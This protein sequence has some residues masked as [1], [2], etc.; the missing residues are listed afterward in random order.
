M[1]LT[2]VRGITLAEVNAGGESAG[3]TG[4]LFDL[5]AWVLVAAVPFGLYYALQNFLGDQTLSNGQSLFLALVSGAVIMWVFRLVP[6]FVPGL[7]LILVAV[8]MNLVPQ[9]IAF[10]GFYSEVFFLIFGIFVL[11]AL[12][13]ETSWLSRLEHLLRRKDA[14]LGARVMAILGSG[15]VL[16]LI[17]PS[18]LGRAAMLQ[19]LVKKFF[20][21]AKPR[22]NSILALVH[23]HA[24]TLISTIILTGNPL[25]FVLL[26]MLSEQARGRYQW[27]GWLK[28][29]GVAGLL[30]AI[31]LVAAFAIAAKT[32]SGN[33]SNDVKEPE[34][35][36]LV[37][38]P[39]L[40]W[41]ALGL[42]GVLIAAIF[43]RSWHQVPLVW[44]ILFLALG[45]FLFSAI[46]ISSLRSKF[47]WPTLV[48]VATVVAWGPMLDHLELSQWIAAQSPILLEQ[49]NK[50]I[51]LGVTI[52]IAV[53]LLIRLAVPGAPAF[54]IIATALLPFAQQVGMSPWVL[55]FI[56]LTV[57]EGFILPY[58][59]GVYSQT[60]SMLDADRV[61]HRG[62]SFLFFNLFF[63]AARIGAIYASIPWW[64]SLDLM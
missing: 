41:G 20:G 33:D 6:D 10:S 39:M 9:E 43:T 58:Q 17:V 22:S 4:E 63:L 59:H 48:F 60:V 14:S 7:G 46:T 24:T 53:T 44:I 34:L 12:L 16:T 25:N 37:K 51:Y 55:G 40:D 28:A 45:V 42:Y 38:K 32:A 1:V 11:A 26:G 64:K 54:I 23:V 8:L 3:A 35:E 29:A 15:V 19:P 21:E 56:V 13:A 52:T 57:S 49:F 2:L 27:L 18:P 50:S 31:L 47:D 61:E 30:L 5:G 62:S 36:P